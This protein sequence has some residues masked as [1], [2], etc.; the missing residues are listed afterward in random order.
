[1]STRRKCIKPKTAR[2]SC[3]P[4]STKSENLRSGKIETSILK[5]VLDSTDKEKVSIKNL[6]HLISKLVAD[7]LKK[8][9]DY[10]KPKPATARPT[11]TQKK[12]GERKKSH[13]MTK[14]S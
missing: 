4:T 7:E 14:R 9:Q 8:H 13:E 6:K 12:I 11:K 2:P 1:M 5:S 10:A 3:A